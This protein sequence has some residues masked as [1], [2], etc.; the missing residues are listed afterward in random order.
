MHTV[1]AVCDSE[2]SWELC[3]LTLYCLVRDLRELAWR[4][5]P[6][7]YAFV[8]CKKI[9]FQKV[10]AGTRITEEENLFPIKSLEPTCPCHGIHWPIV[11]PDASRNSWLGSSVGWSTKTQLPLWLGCSL[12]VILQDVDST[13]A[14]DQYLVLLFTARTQESWHQSVAYLIIITK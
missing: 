13:W 1:I 14:S 9:A 11:Y 4:Q 2:E 8:Q 5:G 10:L 12:N 3:S 7:I 6:V